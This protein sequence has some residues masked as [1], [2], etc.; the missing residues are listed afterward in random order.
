MN[1]KKRKE[2]VIDFIKEYK[3]VSFAIAIVIGQAMGDFLQAVV[4][5]LIMPF[6]DPWIEGTWKTATI[7]LGL[8][9]FGWG[10]VLSTLLN[11]ILLV[12]IIYVIIKKVM[13]YQPLTKN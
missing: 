13:R 7:T 12:I 10:V 8:F 2:N 4:N 3:I 1:N 9:S 5:N 11:L 6:L